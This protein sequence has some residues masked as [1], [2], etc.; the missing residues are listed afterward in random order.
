M[1]HGRGHLSIRP[2]R[3]AG[4]SLSGF[5]LEFSITPGATTLAVIPFAASARAI[6][7]VTTP[8]LAIAYAIRLGRATR[9]CTPA[10]PML[11][12]RPPP[13]A[14]MS[15]IAAKRRD[16]R[17]FTT[18][19][20][21][22]SRYLPR[23]LR[24]P[25]ARASWPSALSSTVFSCTDRTRRHTRAVTTPEHRNEV[26]DALERSFEFRD[27]REALALSTVSGSSPRARTTIPTWRSTTAR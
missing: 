20:A 14:R 2:T 5:V 8:V 19:S 11:T 1:D 16:H 22:V 26:N 25:V 13:A 10:Y 12:M 18:R 23:A 9:L 3:P 15:G 27:F 24:G 4:I 17:A 6:A 7:L 21:S